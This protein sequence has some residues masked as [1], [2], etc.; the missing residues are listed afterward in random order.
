MSGTNY[1]TGG[2]R[3]ITRRLIPQVKMRVFGF[4]VV[5][6]FGS[7]LIAWMTHTLWRQL[8]Q[9]SKDHAAVKSESFYLGVHLRGALRGLNDK[10]LQFGTSHDPTFRDAFLND[11]VELKDWIATNRVL[12]AETAN[13]QLLKGVEVSKQLAL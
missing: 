9:L 7:V 1:S 4:F 5:V 12:L 2:F 8:D 10:L 11:S 6:V 3:R 13:L